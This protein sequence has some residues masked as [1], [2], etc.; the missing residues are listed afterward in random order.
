MAS[1]KRGPRNDNRK[2]SS[3]YCSGITIVIFVA[4]CLVGIWMI[5]SAT[6]VPV[7]FSLADTNRSENRENKPLADLVPDLSER[8]SGNKPEEYRDSPVERAEEEPSLN[9]DQD[10]LKSNSNTFERQVT[11][12]EGNNTDSN[13][14]LGNDSEKALEK[15]NDELGSESSIKGDKSHKVEENLPDVAEVELLNE[16]STQNGSW[17]SQDTESKNEKKKIRDS[18]PNSLTIP[19]KKISHSWKLC[20]VTAGAD[21]IPCLDNEKAIKM[22]R[23]TKHYEHRE[24]HC[25]ELGPTCLVPLPNGYNSAI[26]WPSS[27]DKVHVSL[28]IYFF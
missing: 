6:V 25:P 5:T 18:D 4:F 22:L 28:L 7:E 1:D 19:N 11:K 16:T 20:N 21:Y 9:N 2:S 8:N 3:S 15:I 23:S 24:R 13:S 10:F 14:V 12:E 27:R 17:L 26:K